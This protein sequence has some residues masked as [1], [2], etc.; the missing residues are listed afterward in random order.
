MN[1]ASAELISR[2]DDVIHRAF[3]A[4]DIGT[5]V[6]NA[7][8]SQPKEQLKHLSGFFWLRKEPGQRMGVGSYEPQRISRSTMARR[9][10]TLLDMSGS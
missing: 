7:P 3:L 4:S 1:Q 8:A 10:L 9:S 5:S 2:L 6:G